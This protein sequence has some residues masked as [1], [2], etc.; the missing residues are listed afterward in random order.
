[1]P[2]E[3]ARFGRLVDD[4]FCSNPAA[5]N[6]REYMLMSRRGITTVPG[7]GHR[8]REVVSTGGNILDLAVAML[9]TDT[10]T[11]D[12]IFGDVDDKGVQKVGD[13]AN[14]GI[15]KQGWQMIRSSVP[16]YSKL[17]ASDYK[18][19]AALNS[20]LHWDIAVLHASQSHYGLDVWFK[21]HRAGQRGFDG[22]WPAEDIANYKNAVL[23][24]RDQI[25]ANRKGLA[26]DRKW[27]VEVPPV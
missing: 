18:A 8:K 15:F 1:M 25:A 20:N 7:L 10:M 26:D 24:I 11:A 9:E 12:Y 6:F 3:M 23:W 27:W 21:G 13:A 4:N 22:T 2:F 19:G 14:F 16:E 17:T 5:T